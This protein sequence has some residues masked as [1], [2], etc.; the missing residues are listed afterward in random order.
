M[1]P[2][3]PQNRHRRHPIHLVPCMLQRMPP[4]EIKQLRV[5]L[6][7]SDG[8]GNYNSPPPLS[9]SDEGDKSFQKFSIHG[10]SPHCMMP[11][12]TATDV[13]WHPCIYNAWHVRVQTIL[14][15]YIIIQCPPPSR[16]VRIAVRART[17]K[18][19]TY[20]VD[21]RTSSAPSPASDEVSEY[22]GQKN[23]VASGSLLLY[24]EKYPGTLSYPDH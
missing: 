13:H 14:I 16:P 8:W 24:S 17:A 2:T 3:V 1:S 6:L 10:V 7:C 11:Y 20:R 19:S 18:S 15:A 5:R 12:F 22:I 21:G 9:D 4:Q 23:P